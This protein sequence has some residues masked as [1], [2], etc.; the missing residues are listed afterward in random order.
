[1]VKDGSVLVDVDLSFWPVNWEVS[2]GKKGDT[3]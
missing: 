1:M 3:P 2:D